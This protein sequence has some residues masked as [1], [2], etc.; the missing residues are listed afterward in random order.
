MRL[1]FGVIFHDVANLGSTL[2]PEDSF[3]PIDLG[4]SVYTFRG[5]PLLCLSA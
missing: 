3:M 5:E 2:D 1:R 4:K